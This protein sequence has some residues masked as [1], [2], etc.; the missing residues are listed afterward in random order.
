MSDDP[1]TQRLH[2]T[3]PECGFGDHEWGHLA[4]FDDTHCLVCHMD[5]GRAVRLRRWSASPEADAA[6]PPPPR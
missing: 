1:K 4:L 2:F 3:C 6:A 5:D